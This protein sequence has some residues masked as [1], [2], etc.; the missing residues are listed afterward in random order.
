MSTLSQDSLFLQLTKLDLPKPPPVTKT[1]SDLLEVAASDACE[2]KR[3]QHSLY[4]TV[5]TLRDCLDEINGLTT[6]VK[7]ESEDSWNIFHRYT[8][9]IPNLE[10]LLL[11]FCAW[12]A[13]GSPAPN[14]LSGTDVHVDIMFIEAW[15][16]ARKELQEQD[17]KLLDWFS[18]DTDRNKRKAE[19]ELAYKYDD[20]ALY[21][22]LVSKWADYPAVSTKLG[23]EK[24][25][26]MKQKLDTV[27]SQGNLPRKFR[28]HFIRTTIIIDV[29][30]SGRDPSVAKMA[31]SEDFWTVIILLV[32]AVEVSSTGNTNNFSGVESAFEKLVKFMIPENTQPLPDRYFELHSLF[33]AI[34]RPY[35]AVA[36]AL[37][38]E[39]HTLHLKF[40]DNITYEQSRLLD[41]AIHRT[42]DALEAASAA[43]VTYDPRA[44]W[45]E[46]E[47]VK[48][49]ILKAEAFVIDCLRAYGSSN[50]VQAF[51]TNIKNAR[52]EDQARLVAICTRLTAKTV[53]R[54]NSTIV[55]V[56]VTVGKERRKYSTDRSGTLSS[57]AWLLRSDK[58]LQKTHGNPDSWTRGQFTVDGKEY[59]SSTPVAELK[60]GAQKKLVFSL[61]TPPPK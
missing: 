13:T 57:I 33:G 49:S 9:M 46:V 56:E 38:V 44:K 55:N 34:I 10:E 5:S 17:Q 1:L 25:P 12:S 41:E 37:V 16:K 2:A 59:D 24:F 61:P 32:D 40:R 11:D 27:A 43:Q 39:C 58:E 6:K 51:E 42:K 8:S 4:W 48:N 23:K 31:D 7:G 45:I 14:V 29:S 26:P 54:S 22:A 53:T 18:V 35:Y 21:R 47:A 19:M 30:L 60:N 28:T 20:M 3:N 36:R 52:N 15:M 50:D